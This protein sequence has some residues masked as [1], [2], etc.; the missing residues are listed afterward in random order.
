MARCGTTTAGSW[1]IRRW[2]RCGS[3]QRPLATVTPSTA[4]PRYRLRAAWKSIVDSFGTATAAYT[5]RMPD[6]SMPEIPPP[7]RAR[8]RRWW[9]VTGLCAVVLVLVGTGVVVLRSGHPAVVTTAARAA[10]SAPPASAQP[11]PSRSAM[12]VA[13]PLPTGS[14]VCGARLAFIGPLTGPVSQFGASIHQ[15]A[16]LAIDEYNRIHP[17]CAVTLV[18]LDSRGDELRSGPA[19]RPRCTT[20]GT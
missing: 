3:G 17:G 6:D 14:P 12:A 11:S 10:G 13:G 18:D 19:A 4:S 1:L 7:I 2:R 15:G 8:R 9:L 16:Q 5:A 20:A